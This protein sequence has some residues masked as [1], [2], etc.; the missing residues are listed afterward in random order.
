MP[1]VLKDGDT[2]YMLYAAGGGFS[3]ATSRDG[4][5]W[6]KHASNPVLRGIGESNDPCLRKIG[7]RFVVWYCG[8]VEG[9]YRLLRATSTDCVHW[10]K[11][12]EPIIALGKASEFDSNGHAGP[13]MLQ[14]DDTWF[15]FYLGNDKKKWSAGVATSKDGKTWKKSAANPVLDIGG[16]DAWDGGSLMSLDVHWHVFD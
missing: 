9:R 3:L 4:V 7:D 11:D 5:K 16:P 15:L 1:G 6:Q 2:C 10:E 13:E 8:K 14:V 12:P